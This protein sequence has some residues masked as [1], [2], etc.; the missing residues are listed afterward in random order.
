M[1]P[2]TVVLLLLWGTVVGLDLVTGPQ[3]MVARPLV[4][5]TGAGLVLGQPLEGLVLGVLFEFFQFDVMPVGASRYPEYGPATIAAVTAAHGLAEPVGLA[6]GSLVGLATALLGGASLGWVRRLNTAAVRAAAPALEGGDPRALARV[7]RL[8][9][10]RDALRALLVTAVAL[11][12]A[13]FGGT[14]L[15]GVL[16][17]RPGGLV[18]AVAAGIGLAA[19]AA[20][21]FRLVGRG[22]NLR[23]LLSGVVAGVVL[24][25]L[26]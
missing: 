16:D 1:T 21:A 3:I 20:G 14:V 11:A 18:A 5:G 2:E 10:A 4:A 12:V 9:V 19:A 7:H 17:E 8:G 6:V 23:W 24:V 26:R 15:V 22:P 13:L 25:W